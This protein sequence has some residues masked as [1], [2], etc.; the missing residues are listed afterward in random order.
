MKQT[1]P[2]E[3]NAAKIM[4]NVSVSDFIAG[5]G[6]ETEDYTQ[7][8]PFGGWS[9][10]DFYLTTKLI[11]QNI[12]KFFGQERSAAVR[13]VTSVQQQ[14]SDYC[15][16]PA[17]G[18]T[19]ECACLR[20]YQSLNATFFA[21]NPSSTSITF[22]SQPTIF[23]DLSRRVDMYCDVLRTGNFSS[24]DGVSPEARNNSSFTGFLSYT[25]DSGVSYI[26]YSNACQSLT[27]QG[28]YP[29]LGD[30]TPVQYP[31]LNPMNS[32]LTQYNFAD[33][34]RTLPNNQSML[35]YR[36]WLPACTNPSTAEA[37]FSD[38]L[39]STITCP[40]VCYAYS[41]AT[42]IIVGDIDAN[43]LSMGNF[44]QQCDFAGNTPKDEL[45]AFM[46]PANVIRG[47]QFDV[48]QGYSSTLNIQIQNPELDPS[49]YANSKTIFASSELPKLLSVFPNSS[50]LFRYSLSQFAEFTGVQ[51]SL[52]LSV[53]IN[54]M[55]QSVMYVQ[56]NIWLSDNL[57]SQP[58]RIPVTINIK[59][60]L[61]NK[62]SESN[63]PQACFF[64]RDKIANDVVQYTCNAVDCSFGSNSVLSYG[65]GCGNGLQSLG[66]VVLE[67]AD[68]LRYFRAHMSSNSSLRDTGF[69]S[70]HS[71]T[72]MAVTALTRKDRAVPVLSRENVAA[73]GFQQLLQAHTEL[74]G[75]PFNLYSTSVNQSA[76]RLA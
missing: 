48:P 31:T 25:T 40:S 26:T 17:T 13:R 68:Y 72:P 12:N 66:G 63:W 54:A 22:F 56:T 1:T 2:T 14:V 69:I 61:S 35:P 60:S 45:S 11:A 53:T 76:W 64:S 27:A 19:G 62:S 51:D 52:N 67:G 41:G 4:T 42:N 43:V 10:N 74:Y 44:M 29:S 8:I 50:T 58:M 55:S 57:R 20:G 49:R 16:D 75:K 36:C 34:I 47:F 33:A 5:I 38:L 46:V 39:S 21:P 32:L 7:G 70:P 30:I 73:Q 59:S 3:I 18:G 23:G 37:V 28:Q 65:A 15:F 71:N 6:Q 24:N 9:C